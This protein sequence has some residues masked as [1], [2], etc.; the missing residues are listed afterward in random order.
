MGSLEVC[1]TRRL[2][3][4]PLSAAARAPNA[5]AGNA[6]KMPPSVTTWNASTPRTKVVSMCWSEKSKCF[7]QNWWVVGDRHRP[8]HNRRPSTRLSNVHTR[9]VIMNIYFILQEGRGWFDVQIENH[10]RRT[11]FITYYYV[12]TQLNFH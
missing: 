10:T 7:L 6:R 9:D 4:V 8:P 2:R 11:V 1:V 5:P 12:I 3:C